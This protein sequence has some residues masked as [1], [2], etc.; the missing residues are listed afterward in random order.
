LGQKQQVSHLVPVLSPEGFAGFD[1]RGKGHDGGQEQDGERSHGADSITGTA[2]APQQARRKAPPGAELGTWTF[3]TFRV[4]ETPCPS[5]HQP[6]SMRKVQTNSAP[7][8]T[9]IS[10][11][12]HGAA[13]STRG[14]IWCG[15]RALPT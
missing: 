4:S 5:R 11:N 7:S 9:A 15:A 8:P 13:D 14:W 3:L 1:G 10:W 2:D 12:W 6:G